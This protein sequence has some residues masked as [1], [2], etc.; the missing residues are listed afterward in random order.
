MGRIGIVDGSLEARTPGTRARILE[1]ISPGGF[2]QRFATW[3][4]SAA[5]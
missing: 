2:E 1:I 4:N 5:S 3:T